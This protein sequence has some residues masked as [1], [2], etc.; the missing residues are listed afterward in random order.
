M[1]NPSDFNELEATLE[2]ALHM[3][4]HRPP[5]RQHLV[6]PGAE[7]QFFRSAMHPTGPAAATQAQ[8]TFNGGFVG[9]WSR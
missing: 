5:R 3:S 6:N 9:S 1:M 8:T 2:K 4:W 7:A